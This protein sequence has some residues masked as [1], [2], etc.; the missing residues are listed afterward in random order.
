M[1]PFSLVPWLACF[2]SNFLAGNKIVCPDCLMVSGL[3]RYSSYTSVNCM[4]GTLQ[5]Q[6]LLRVCFVVGFSIPLAFVPYFQ[7]GSA[8]LTKARLSID[9]THIKTGFQRTGMPL[10]NYSSVGLSLPCR[11]RTTSNPVAQW[12]VWA[13]GQRRWESTDQSAAFAT[14]GPAQNPPLRLHYTRTC[15][16]VPSHTYSKWTSEDSVRRHNAISH[17]N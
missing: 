17:A 13:H 12:W 5:P 9:H 3:K 16:A 1:H 7:L 6:M 11:C 4:P 8:E 10:N 14:T 15:N 2:S